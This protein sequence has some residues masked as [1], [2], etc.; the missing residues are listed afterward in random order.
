MIKYFKTQQ[1]LTC[2]NEEELQKALLLT[3]EIF[4]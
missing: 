2:I 3:K 4:Q 1:M